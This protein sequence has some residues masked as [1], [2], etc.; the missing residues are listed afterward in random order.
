M[1]SWD[2][3]AD[4]RPAPPAAGD[5]PA[6]QPLMGV[7]AVRDPTLEGLRSVEFE[8]SPD[9]IRALMIID[10]RCITRA[11]AEPS[12]RGT[13]VT[14]GFNSANAMARYARSARSGEP[15]RLAGGQPRPR[16]VPRLVEHAC[17]T[18][19]IFRISVALI[20][21][22]WRC[23]CFEREFTR[24]AEH[25]SAARSFQPGPGSPGARGSAMGDQYPW[26]SCAQR[27]T[28][29]REIAANHDS[30]GEPNRWPDVR[31]AAIRRS[32][33]WRPVAQGRAR[34]VPGAQPVRDGVVI[35]VL[36]RPGQG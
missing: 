30:D 12:L 3:R 11:Q 29:V 9:T 28:G 1:T 16:S 20:G 4:R 35:A 10:T 25:D 23:W 24:G 18:R 34:L 6:R 2:D 36:R 13:A 26:S 21:R 14:D 27:F 33:R 22:T 19:A 8:D 5:L 17:G 31:P 32:S 15:A 7:P